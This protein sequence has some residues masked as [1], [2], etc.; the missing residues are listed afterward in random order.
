MRRGFVDRT[1]TLASKAHMP[2][3][4]MSLS[5]VRELAGPTSVSVGGAVTWG[6]AVAATAA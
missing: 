4:R 5:Q 2:R 1:R 3:R 6:S